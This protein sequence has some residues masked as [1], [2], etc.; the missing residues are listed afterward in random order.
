M[1]HLL[2]LVVRT[3]L[4]QVENLHQINIFSRSDYA[5]KSN[6]FNLNIYK[7]KKKKISLSYLL[8]RYNFRRQC[9][10]RKT[11]FDNYV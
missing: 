4:S 11:D 8:K 6:F 7:L 10:L 5:T 1:R 2:D 9:T 3:P